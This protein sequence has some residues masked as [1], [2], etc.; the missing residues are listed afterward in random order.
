[1][2]F[3]YNK[4]HKINLKKIIA[5]GMSLVVL[6]GILGVI[7]NVLSGNDNTSILKTIFT[8]FGNGS[9]NIHYI[10]EHFPEKTNF[11]FGYTF[12]I[13]F[14]MLLPGPNIDFTI[15][16]KNIL[17]ETF[18]GGGLTPTLLGEFYINFGYIGIVLGFILLGFLVNWL[19]QKYQK[20]KNAYYVAFLVWCLLSSVRGGFSNTEINFILFSCVYVVLVIIFDFYNRYIEKGE[21]K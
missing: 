4:Y 6:V 17:G 19:E 9:I 11:Q 3:I 5:L 14:I 7:R 20:G 18:E 2:I 1:M 16:L 21:Q 10:L 12:L 8:L 15:W 13:N